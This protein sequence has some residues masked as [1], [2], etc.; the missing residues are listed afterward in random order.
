MTGHSKSGRSAYMVDRSIS[1]REDTEI[2]MLRQT[3][4]ADQVGF[5]NWLKIC[6][7]GS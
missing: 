6:L 5:A 7:A 1:G 2:I 4:L 3:G